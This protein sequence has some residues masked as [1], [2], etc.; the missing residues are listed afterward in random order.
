[1]PYERLRS[2]SMKIRDAY[3]L[4]RLGPVASGGLQAA[5]MDG[6]AKIGFAV[7]VAVAW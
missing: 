4:C 6:V 1:M 5:V 2:R 7:A 3:W